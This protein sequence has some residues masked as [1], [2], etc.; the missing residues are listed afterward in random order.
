MEPS[1][2]EN[3]RLTNNN[4]DADNSHEEINKEESSDEESI[5]SRRI[6][7]SMRT[8]E[9]RTRTIRALR[10]MDGTSHNVRGRYPLRNRGGSSYYINKDRNKELQYI[11]NTTVTSDPGEPKDIWEAV[12]GKDKEKWIASIESEIQ[13]FRKSC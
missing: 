9:A 2:V 8:K 6:T 3:D 12:K 4:N 13:N 7:R 1:H 5:R 10:N 11:H